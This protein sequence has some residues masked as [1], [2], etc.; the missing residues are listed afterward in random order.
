MISKRK[1]IR[2]MKQSFHFI[3]SAAYFS[4][5]NTRIRDDKVFCGNTDNTFS[6]IEITINTILK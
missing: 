4:I 5:N 2:L 1:I 3:F 6:L